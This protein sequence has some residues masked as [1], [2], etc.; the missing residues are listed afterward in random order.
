MNFDS[1]SLRRQIPFYL[2][3]KD[4][5]ELIRELRSVSAE[6][7]VKYFLNST[8]DPYRS[9]V[10]Q[11]DGWHGLQLFIFESGERRSVKGVV[12]SNSCDID[13]ANKRD[14]PTKLSFSPLVRLERYK[15]VL[16]EEGIDIKRIEDKLSAIRSQKTSNIFYFP[17]DSNLD[18][19]YIV[20]LDDIYS[21]PMTAFASGADQKKVFTLSMTG[22]YLFILKLSYHFCRM[23]ES[24]IRKP[25]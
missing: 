14:L 7:T 20:R 19:E 6:Q 10:L 2:T 12:V 13:P 25:V 3:S 22:F 24:V 5:E 9:E 15:K 1:D 21:M 16:E 4:Q 18:A 23:Q 8:L 11:G 17:R